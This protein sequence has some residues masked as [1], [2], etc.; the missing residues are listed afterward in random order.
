MARLPS[1]YPRRTMFDRYLFYFP[2]L[3][4]SAALISPSELRRDVAVERQPSS[5]YSS[6][7]TAELICNETSETEMSELYS[8]IGNIVEVG[9]LK[10]GF[11]CKQSSTCWLRR[12]WPI[13]DRK[14]IPVCIQFYRLLLHNLF[15]CNH[16]RLATFIAMKM[17]CERGSKSIDAIKRKQAAKMLFRLRRPRAEWEEK[18]QNPWR[19]D[20]ETRTWEVGR[21][22]ETK[23]YVWSFA[24]WI[25]NHS[26]SPDQEFSARCFSIKVA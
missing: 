6:P 17:S 14:W 20:D 25:M 7:A 16:E 26:P 5:F 3:N 1:R 11:D 9:S 22:Q 24:D 8:W 10:N 13:I 4:H 23:L 18:L 15:P 21:K 19:C 12:T 2:C